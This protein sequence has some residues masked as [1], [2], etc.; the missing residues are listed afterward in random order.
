MPEQRAAEELERVRANP[1]ELRD[2]SGRGEA[3]ANLRG[4]SRR[5]REG[6]RAMGTRTELFRVR[7]RLLSPK[8]GEG[9]T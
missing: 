5:Q 7:G 6:R 8:R 3:F 1:L 9:L 4:V 2:P